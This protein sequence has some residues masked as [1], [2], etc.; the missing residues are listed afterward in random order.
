MRREK[1]HTRIRDAGSQAGG[2]QGGVKAPA[3]PPDTESELSPNVDAK[4][5]RMDEGSHTTML[6]RFSMKILIVWVLWSIWEGSGLRGQMSH[7][8]QEAQFRA[9]AGCW[10]FK[11]LIK[12]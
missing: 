4:P 10:C 3:H 8:H 12:L 7:C 9:S 11:F 6:E 5:S 1:N 2:M